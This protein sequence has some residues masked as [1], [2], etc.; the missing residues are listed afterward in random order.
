LQNWTSVVRSLKDPSNRSYLYGILLVASTVIAFYGFQ[1]IKTWLFLG[2]AVSATY[3]VY[4]TSA[5]EFDGTI[6]C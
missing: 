6:C 1:M 4:T 3:F 2:G 5:A